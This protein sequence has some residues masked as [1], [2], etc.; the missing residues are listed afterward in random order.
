[1]T[2]P[3]PIVYIDLGVGGMTCDDCVVHVTNALESVP[4]VE[5]AT[6]DFATRS[7]VVVARADVEGSALAQAVRATGQYNAFE[8]RRRSEH[9]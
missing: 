6:V 5:G 3:D 9:A 4:G 2:N 8:R 7:A 1:M